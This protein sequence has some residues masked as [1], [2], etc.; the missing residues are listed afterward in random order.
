MLPSKEVK[1]SRSSL[2]A[3]SLEVSIRYIVLHLLVYYLHM[4]LDV[5]AHIEIKRDSKAVAAYAFE[6]TNDP[7]WIGGISQAK[8][9]TPLP[10]DKRTQVKRRA[11]FNDRPIDSRLQV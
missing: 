5:T 3:I 7:I 2:I 1:I 8:L 4:A 6:P 11:K 9:L 10:V